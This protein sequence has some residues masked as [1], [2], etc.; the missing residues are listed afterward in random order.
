MDISTA[1]PPYDPEFPVYKGRI[2]KGGARYMRVVTVDR[3][4]RPGVVS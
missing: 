3:K 2:N 1:H 4:D